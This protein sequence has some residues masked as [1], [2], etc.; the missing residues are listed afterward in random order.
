MNFALFP[1]LAALMLALTKRKDSR[2]QQSRDIA[3]PQLAAMKDRILSMY[4]ITFAT[5]NDV[6][7]GFALACHRI[8][9]QSKFLG[10]TTHV[11]KSFS[12][13][14]FIKTELDAKFPHIDSITSSDYQFI[15]AALTFYKLN[16]QTAKI[17]WTSSN[18]ERDALDEKL[19]FL[20]FLNQ[21]EFSKSNDII[22]EVR[23]SRNKLKVQ[24]IINITTSHSP[25]LKNLLKE[26]RLYWSEIDACPFS[27]QRDVRL[28]ITTFPLEDRI[29]QK[30][31]ESFV[32]NLDP[33][34]NISKTIPIPDNSTD[35][36]DTQAYK[37]FLNK[38][39]KVNTK[40][41]NNHSRTGQFLEKQ[42]R[43]PN[44][45]AL[46]MSA[47]P[48]SRPYLLEDWR[49][50]TKY[51]ILRNFSIEELERFAGYPTNWISSKNRRLG[52]AGKALAISSN[53][54]V[55]E[56]ILQSYALYYFKKFKPGVHYG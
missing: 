16:L 15:S 28:Y 45:C 32:V 11:T 27:G 7:G 5:G 41:K 25:K 23:Y 12:L 1:T 20:T 10:Y 50:N 42:Q 9:P 39:G 31:I 44:N 30:I 38:S 54:L 49:L 51:P 55:L 2:Y 21:F 29:K 52:E 34:S 4:P 47:N 43:Y 40:W 17:S 14:R 22:I 26:G 19:N 33:V 48:L 24:D 56:Y 35:V 8:F 13:N 46:K 6:L 53:P 37:V 36:K 3:K 18:N